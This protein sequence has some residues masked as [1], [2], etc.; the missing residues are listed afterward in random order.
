[1]RKSLRTDLGLA[2]S[3][4]L[5]L[6]SIAIISQQNS[7]NFF[8]NSSLSSFYPDRKAIGVVFYSPQRLKTNSCPSS[9]TNLNLVLSITRNSCLKQRLDNF[10]SFLWLIIYN[11]GEFPKTVTQISEF[12]A[13]LQNTRKCLDPSASNIFL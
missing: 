13:S 4:K 3:Q 8:S 5:E 6:S 10:R 1:M 2:G 9:F 11:F 12:P 7:R